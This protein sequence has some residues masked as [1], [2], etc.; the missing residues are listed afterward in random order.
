MS[1]SHHGAVKP[2]PLYSS[3]FESLQING[4]RCVKV[5]S[6]ALPHLRSGEP[7]W[8]VSVVGAEKWKIQSGLS[9]VSSSRRGG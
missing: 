7:K 2:N 3:S 9:N 5:E 4:K 8:N 1:Q 6:P